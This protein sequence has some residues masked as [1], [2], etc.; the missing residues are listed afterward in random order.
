MCLAIYKPAC[1]S[2]PKEHLENGFYSNMDGAGIAYTGSG[3]L[4]IIKPL[5]TFESFYQAYQEIK[6]HQMMIHF[7]W[8][9]SGSFQDVH[10]FLINQ[11]LAVC[12]NGML[13][14]YGSLS[15]SDTAHFVDSRLIPARSNAWKTKKF[16][17]QIE[18]EIYPGKLVFLHANGEYKIYNES[19]GE[20]RDSCWYSNDS[21]ESPWIQLSRKGLRTVRAKQKWEN[22]N[23]DKAVASLL[24]KGFQAWKTQENLEICDICYEGKL[25]LEWLEGEW[26]CSDCLERETFVCHWCKKRKSWD[27]LAFPHPWKENTCQRCGEGS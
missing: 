6:A 21:Y 1:V 19:L 7:R 10:P 16:Q 9:T 25:E 27:Q 4:H 5:W 13:Q 11:S 26:I 12:H 24:E 3:K 17:R 22:W 20:W 14:K 23:E 18:T 8:A 2:I 15:Q